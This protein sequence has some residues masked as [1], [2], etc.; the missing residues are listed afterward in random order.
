MNDVTKLLIDLKDDKNAAFVAK[1]T[2][3]VEKGRILGIRTPRL[4][5]LA[6]TLYKTPEAED[7]LRDIPHCY[8]EENT[9]HLFI[10][11][12]EKDFEKAALKVDKFLPYV[13]NW[14]TCDGFSSVAFKKNPDSLIHYID[15]WITSGQ[16]YTI[17]FGVLMLMKYYLDE[18]FTPE[19]LEKVSK[20]QSDEYY[21]NMM[22]AW[23]FATAL[24]KQR[25]YTI[26]YIEENRL[27]DFCHNKTIQKARESFR[28]SDSEKEYLKT[29]KR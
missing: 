19:V 25:N 28:I 29:L 4:R 6:K 22:I 1:L 12:H 17:R 13:D 2:P 24:A 21:V 27:S 7:F 20:I 15:K 5:Q 11:G 9:L 10:L 26:K 23:F 8:L 14:A 18:N 16:T 3:T